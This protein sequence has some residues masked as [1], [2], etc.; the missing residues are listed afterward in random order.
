MLMKLETGF[1]DFINSNL[2]QVFTNSAFEDTSRRG[3][4]F[5]NLNK[6][7]LHFLNSFNDYESTVL[8]LTYYI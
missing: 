2:N 4:L 1:L 5:L 3:F 8:C 7:I 6:N